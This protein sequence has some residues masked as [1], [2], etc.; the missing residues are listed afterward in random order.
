MSDLRRDKFEVWFYKELSASSGAEHLA[1]QAWQAAIESVVI[2]F[3]EEPYFCPSKTEV[4]QASDKGYSDA[5]E[6][7]KKAITDAGVK[8][9]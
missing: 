1:W 2:E 7:V 3:T 9:K 5:L 8:Y 4:E 6:M